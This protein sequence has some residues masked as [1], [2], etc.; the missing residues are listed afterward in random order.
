MYDS[1]MAMMNNS[2]DLARILW[3]SGSFVMLLS[4]FGGVICVVFLFK[5]NIWP[6]YFLYIGDTLLFTSLSRNFRFLHFSNGNGVKPGLSRGMGLY[7]SIASFP[8]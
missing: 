3:L 4:A 1:T 2:T 8:W 5:T 7:P 6:F